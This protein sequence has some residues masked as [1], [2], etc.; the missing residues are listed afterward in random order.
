MFDFHFAC[1]HEGD[2][3][4]FRLKGFATHNKILHLKEAIIAE[5]K[6]ME[7]KSFKVMFDLR[8]LSALDPRTAQ[9]I[10]EIDDF[11]CNECTATKIGTVLDNIVA[12]LQHLR[13]ARE[14]KHQEQFDKGRARIFSDANE[15]L[16]W[17]KAG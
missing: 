2:I 12:K 1:S 6:S 16:A 3:V 15:C 11:L 4:C 10:G 5:L 7:N 17:L 13:L 8:G 14:G 9:A